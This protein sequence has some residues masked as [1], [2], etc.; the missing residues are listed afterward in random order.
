MS[1]PGLTRPAGTWACVPTKRTGRRLAKPQCQ[2]GALTTDVLAVTRFAAVQ[3]RNHG[4][5]MQ[6]AAQKAEAGKLNQARVVVLS[7]AGL[8]RSEASSLPWGDV[9]C[10]DDGSGGVTVARSKTDP[11]AV[12]A[13]VAITQLQC[14]RFPP[15]GRRG[16]VEE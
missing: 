15:S 9:Q 4:R 12:R 5:G 2:C 1:G 10:W 8:R 16:L 3:P 14:R 6:A 7:D 13:V 11:E